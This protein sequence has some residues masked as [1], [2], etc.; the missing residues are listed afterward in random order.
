MTAT[1]DRPLQQGPANGGVAARRAV[2]RWAWRLFRHDWRQ[3]VVVTVLLAL[4]VAGAVFG[5][6]AAY[7]LTPAPDARFGTANHLLRLDGSDPQALA[8]N[9][10]AARKAFGSVEVVGHRFAPISGS[11]ETLEFRAKDPRGVYGATTIAL[12]QGR[13]PHGAGEVALTDGAARTLGLGTGAT[14]HLDGQARRVVGVVENPRDLRDEFALVSPAGSA[15]PQAVTVLFKASP[16]SFDAFRSAARTP[17]DGEAREAGRQ[18][19]AANG[20]LAA[21]IVLLLLVSLVTA[22]AFAVVAQRRLR[23]IGMLAAI[24][25]TQ[26]HL[27]LVML[28][29]GAVVGAVA[30]VVGTFAGVMCWAGTAPSLESA[31]EHRIGRFS[32]PWTLAVECMILAVVMATGAAWWPARTVARV[33]ITRALADR[34][35]R[36]KPAHRPAVLAVVFLAAG[37]ACL[38][39]ADQKNPLLIIAG[40]LATVLGILFVSPLAIK[41]LAGAGARAP[42]AVRLAFRDLGRHQARSGAALAAISLALGIPI[43]IIIVATAAQDTAATGNLSD[44]QILIRVGRPND[45]V[46]PIH[47]AAE[48]RG[49]DAQVARIADGLGH[50]KV[51]PLS[52]AVDPTIKPEPGSEEGQGGQPVAE[53]GIPRNP[54]SGGRAGGRASGSLASVPVYVGTPE[55]LR[56]LGVD[57]ATVVP[58]TDVVTV[59]NGEVDIPNVTHPETVTNVERIKGPAYKSL[60]S[61]MLT[62]GGIERRHWQ[63][64]RSGWLVES[65]RPLTAAQLVS[66]RHVAAGAGVTIETRNAQRSL[67]RIRAGAVAAGMLLA[68]GVLAMTV[69]LIRIEASRDLRTLAATGADA[70]IRRTITAATSAGLAFLGVVLGALGAYLG[71][72]AGYSGQLDLLGRVPVPYLAAIAVGVPVAAAGAGWLFAGREPPAISRHAVE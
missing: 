38:A 15:A 63:R 3:Q 52:M 11:V 49:L 70:R 35:P 20:A 44:R 31:A 64:I 55:L 41:V 9:I 24:G 4:A 42:I 27:R 68:L 53:L 21:A 13:L 66:A 7:N 71:L 12:D 1:L 60:P 32:V 37:A 72:A 2:I 43:A 23:Q 47:T 10:A 19:V 34:P 36:P 18:S 26:K 58:A 16:E 28:T 56:Y 39:L 22:A 6:S 29:N 45:P 17:I 61:S 8:A 50:A 69:G 51:I 5:A 30:G 46:I 33:P 65:G 40:T 59:R 14:L 62:T 25:A 54:G 67:A 48:L 57:P